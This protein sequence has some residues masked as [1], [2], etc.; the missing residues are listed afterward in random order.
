LPTLSPENAEMLFVEVQAPQEEPLED[1]W[2]GG[3]DDTQNPKS[4]QGVATVRL[5]SME[6]PKRNLGGF[7][8]FL[9]LFKI[10]ENNVFVL[11]GFCE[12]LA[13]SKILVRGIPSA[14]LL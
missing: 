3:E 6:R 7:L 10:L 5:D 11:C 4:R 13:A 9:F 8:V 1:P 12:G 2:L 14:S